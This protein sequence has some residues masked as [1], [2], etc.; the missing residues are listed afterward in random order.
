MSSRQL[1]SRQFCPAILCG[2]RGGVGAVT[3]TQKIPKGIKRKSVAL[4]NSRRLKGT[5]VEEIPIAVSCVSGSNLG[6][7]SIEFRSAGVVWTR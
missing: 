2:Q 6:K 3:R 5:L 7:E 1:R 4:E